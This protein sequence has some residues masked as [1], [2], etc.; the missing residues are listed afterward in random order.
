MIQCDILKTERENTVMSTRALTEY[1][2][3]FYRAADGIHRLQ[4]NECE[5]HGVARDKGLLKLEDMLK[6]DFDYN[7]PAD[8]CCSGMTYAAQIILIK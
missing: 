6:N 2:R 8:L 3:R 5:H 1:L 4:K 7:L